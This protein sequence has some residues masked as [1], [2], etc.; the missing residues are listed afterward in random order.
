MRALLAGFVATFFF[1]FCLYVVS[2]LVGGWTID[3]VGM[4]ARLLGVSWAVGLLVQLLAGTVLL[5]VLYLRV[6]NP[7]LVGSPAARGLT[8][9]LM[10][11]ILSQT[12]VLP[13]LGAGF[14][15]AHSGGVLAAVDSLIAYAAYGQ[16]FGVLWGGLRDSASSPRGGSSF[17]R[18]KRHVG[19]H[20]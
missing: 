13:M 19:Q 1:T 2:P 11:W 14:F 5:P 7:M 10:L 17:G 4:L 15:G 9:G 12:I 3:L 8:W 18:P 20:A 6:V 16:L